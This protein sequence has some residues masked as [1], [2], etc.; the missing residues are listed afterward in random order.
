MTEIGAGGTACELELSMWAGRAVVFL[1]VLLRKA[2]EGE[3]RHGT[4][5][6]GCGEAPLA[7]GAAPA[8]KVF[9]FSPDHTSTHR[10]CPFSWG[11]TEGWT[12]AGGEEQE[13]T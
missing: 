5:Q 10:L 9:V 6:A 7:V 8:R 4:L 11:S 13:Y 12:S 2:I 1:K 3:S